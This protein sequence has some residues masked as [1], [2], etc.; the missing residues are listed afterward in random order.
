M[1][2]IDLIVRE[3]FGSRM[4]KATILS[5]LNIVSELSK[6]PSLDVP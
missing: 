1:G 4:Q 6:L 3:L 5:S 2:S